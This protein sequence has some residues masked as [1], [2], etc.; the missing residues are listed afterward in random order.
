MRY[1][2]PSGGRYRVLGP[3]MGQ[4][5]TNITSASGVARPASDRSNSGASGERD[6]DCGEAAAHLGDQER[7]PA[8]AILD[9][10]VGVHHRATGAHDREAAGGGNESGDEG[11]MGRHTLVIDAAAG[12]ST[13]S[14][15]GTR[16]RSCA[17][18]SARVEVL[19]ARRPFVRP[20]G[21]PE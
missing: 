3:R 21:S 2:G 4:R 7:G 11:S 18:L 19:G 10:D 13:P 5:P 8:S 17:A 6:R 15:G 1:C 12:G 16:T 14:D 9:A 20:P